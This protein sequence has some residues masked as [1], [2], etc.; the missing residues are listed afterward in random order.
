MRFEFSRRLKPPVQCPE[1][2]QGSLF[3]H[4]MND[5]GFQAPGG[6]A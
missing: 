5:G 1:L 4:H 3:L 2:V 6:L